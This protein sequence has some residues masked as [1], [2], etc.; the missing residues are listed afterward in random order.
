M[1]TFLENILNSSQLQSKN[2]HKVQK[3]NHK[4]IQTD[5]SVLNQLPTSPRT[6]YRNYNIIKKCIYMFKQ[7][8][9]FI[10]E[11]TKMYT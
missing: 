10:K 5:V 7:H 6:R 11:E 1:E 4:D 2:T 8:V 9:D 3:L